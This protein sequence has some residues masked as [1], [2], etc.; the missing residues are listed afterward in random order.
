MSQGQFGIS[1][2]SREVVYCMEVAEYGQEKLSRKGRTYEME[3]HRLCTPRVTL[4]LVMNLV[5][6]N[7]CQMMS[8]RFP[9][10]FSVHLIP[11]RRY[12]QICINLM[13]T[14]NSPHMQSDQG[15]DTLPTLALIDSD[16]LEFLSRWP[17]LSLNNDYVNVGC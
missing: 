5:W 11:S 8:S 10:R 13:Q 17:V 9:K 2:R 3:L 6:L 14:L 15:L 12:V 16:G 1:P 7:H 4:A